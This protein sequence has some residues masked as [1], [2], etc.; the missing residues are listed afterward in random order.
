MNVFTHIFVYED[1]RRLVSVG[2]CTA[3]AGVLAQPE[4]GDLDEAASVA[5]V[6]G[7]LDI[8]AHELF[9]VQR[10]FRRASQDVNVALVQLELNGAFDVLLRLVDAAAGKDALRAY[11]RAKCG[12]SG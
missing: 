11:T 3:Q 2:R 1:K 7:A 10:L 4:G 8:H 5:R 12:G 6:V 9:V